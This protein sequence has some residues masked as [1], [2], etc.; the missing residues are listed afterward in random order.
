MAQPSLGYRQCEGGRRCDCN[1]QASRLLK[2]Q[3]KPRL[4]N[5]R[6]GETR[7]QTEWKN[8]L[9]LAYILGLALLLCGWKASPRWLRQV[10]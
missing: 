10:K 2:L 5:R 4:R 6:R 7:R 9:P 1:C 3:I 8:P